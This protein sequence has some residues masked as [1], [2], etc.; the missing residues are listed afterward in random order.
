[1]S[2]YPLSASCTL[3]CSSRLCWKLLQDFFEHVHVSILKFC[4]IRNLLFRLVAV[5]PFCFFF[6]SR[7]NKFRLLIFRIT[8]LKL[9]PLPSKK[10][11]FVC[12]EMDGFSSVSKFF[13]FL[14]FS[15]SF[16]FLFLFS[17]Q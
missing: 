12:N 10:L 8:G 16:F 1:M 3:N 2:R 9:R 4:F 7:I 15:F 13:S 11:L 14:K 6:I 17:V 5:L